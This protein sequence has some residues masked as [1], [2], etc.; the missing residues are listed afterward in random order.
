VTIRGAP[1]KVVGAL[2]RRSRI[3]D[4]AAAWSRAYRATRASR[5]WLAGARGRATREVRAVRSDVA[6]ITRHL[7]GV[8]RGLIQVF[9]SRPRG[10]GTEADGS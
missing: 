5:D 4:A 6:V 10:S 7:A 8:G 9:T 3:D 1:I 2:R